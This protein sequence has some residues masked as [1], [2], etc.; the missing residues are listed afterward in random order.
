MSSEYRK[1]G[2][3]ISALFSGFTTED[4]RQANSFTRGWKETVGDKIGAHSKIIDVDRGNI[5][6]EVDH[7]GWSQQILFRKKQILYHLSRAFPEL[8]ITNLVIRVVSECKTGYSRPTV[9][10]GAGLYRQGTQGDSRYEQE[11]EKDL[12]ISENLSPELKELFGKLRE[13]V[14]KGKPT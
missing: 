8:H 3:V 4:L 13:S 6:V 12:R 11:E 2:E 10:V 1:A 7:P 9:E 14:K 5:V